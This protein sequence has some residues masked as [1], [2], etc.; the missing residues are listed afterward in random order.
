MNVQVDDAHSEQGPDGVRYLCRI[1]DDE[2]FAYARRGHDFFRVRDHMLWAHESEDFL[3][4]ARSGRPL[5]R[6]A[7]GVF[8]DAE[9]GLPLYYERADQPVQF[10]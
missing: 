3:L 5:A 8:Y 7:G 4:S 1:E 6:G 10:F 2:P 9:N